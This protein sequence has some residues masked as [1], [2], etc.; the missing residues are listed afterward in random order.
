MIA[1]NYQFFGEWQ[2]DS[3]IL[4]APSQEW[5]AGV[6]VST[7][8]QFID[9]GHNVLLVADTDLS[10]ET[11]ELASECG[12]EFDEEETFIVDH[13][14]SQDGDSTS[15]IAGNIQNNAVILGKDGHTT[16]VLYKELHKT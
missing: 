6:S 7:V 10:R 16:P 15:V 1:F 5:P 13:F 2:Y 12:V 3:L 4:F 14:H 8:I 11:R 9:A